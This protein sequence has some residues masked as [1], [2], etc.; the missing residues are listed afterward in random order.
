MLAP[1]VRPFGGA[2]V[3][4]VNATAA[5]RRCFTV[6]VWRCCCPMMMA[7]HLQGGRHRGAGGLD[8]PVVGASVSG[9]D[10]EAM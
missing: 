4:E 6:A 2:P 8:R 1:T 5:V 7:E 10:V 9:D 3:A